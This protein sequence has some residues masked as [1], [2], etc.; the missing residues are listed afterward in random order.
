MSNNLSDKAV[1]STIWSFADVVLSKGTTFIIGLIL[2]RL[3][4]PSD[5][6]LIGMMAIFIA[7]CDTFIESGLS[8]ALV[9]KTDRSK[10]DCSTA[11]FFNLLLSIIAYL[12]LF[13]G[14][15]FISDFFNEGELRIL[16]KVLGLNVVLFALYLV[17]NALVIS[18]FSTKILARINFISNLLSGLVA[19]LLAYSGFGVWA[20]VVQS[21]LVHFLKCIGFW[22][23]VNWRPTFSLSRESIRYLWGYGSK[24][25]LIGLLGTFFNN[26]YNLLIGKCFT[27]QDLGYY[28]RAQ[29]FVQLPISI[30][31]STF[32]K[33]S[34]A[35]FAVL[36]EDK[37]HLKEVYRKYIDLMAFFVFPL[38]ILLSALARPLILFLLT[39]K[40]QMCIIML[41]IL[42]IGAA[43]SPLGILNICLLQAIN[44]VGFSLKL[45]IAKKSVYVLI[46][47]IT[48]PLG[49]LPMV[50]GVAG[51]NVVGTLMN[52]F[53]S[54]KFIDYK[55]REQL[56]DI[57]KYFVVAALADVLVQILFKTINASIFFQLILGSILFLSFY[58]LIT[59]LFNFRAWSNLNEI[60]NKILHK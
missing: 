52:F 48:F 21:L 60:G 56:S 39:E 16:I 18:A 32:M 37:A 51:Y 4:S 29:Q 13:L 24:S 30:I 2:A 1:W 54:R 10:S 28:T 14:S 44:E 41:Q 22:M 23:S 20:L 40:W 33:V 8:N 59:R 3:L 25:L 5:F 43:F 46:I 34:V 53:G 27:K 36:Q 17:P 58:L 45:E 26:I 9:R 6:G 49:L 12:I 31:E 11:F 50:I 55:Y 57:G 42:S 19:I 15:G 47:L 35:T 7:L 38:C